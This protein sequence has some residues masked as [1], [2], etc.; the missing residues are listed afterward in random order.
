MTLVTLITRS[1]L[2]EAVV[3][4]PAAAAAL[5]LSANAVVVKFT[6]VTWGITIKLPV[7]GGRGEMAL[8]WVTSH[9]NVAKHVLKLAHTHTHTDPLHAPP[10]SC[11]ELRNTSPLLQVP[12]TDPRW[13]F[14]TFSGT[15]KYDLLCNKVGGSVDPVTCSSCGAVWSKQ[16]V[17]DGGQGA[18]AVLL[19]RLE[20]TK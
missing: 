19:K 20:G 18:A 13:P 9:G 12:L 7:W 8:S 15:W 5:M 10:P 6:A 16:P 2:T 11:G 1:Y 14:H 4:E 3:Y 17:Q